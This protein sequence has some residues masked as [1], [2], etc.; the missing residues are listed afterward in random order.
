[1]QQLQMEVMGVSPRRNL[2]GLVESVDKE[3]FKKNPEI[4]NKLQVTFDAQKK[5]L[6][7]DT[8]KL[9]KFDSEADAM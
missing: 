5:K 2:E 8:A 6:E 7:A 1:M 9:D 3:T 4:M